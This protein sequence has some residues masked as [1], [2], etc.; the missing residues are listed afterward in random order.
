MK[1]TKK[2]FLNY[3]IV[4]IIIVIAILVIGAN[5]DKLSAFG[6]DRIEF[7]YTHQHDSNP[8]VIGD[9]QFSPSELTYSCGPTGDTIVRYPE[10][11][12]ECWGSDVSYDAG[13]YPFTAGQTILLNQYLS[14][15]LKPQGKVYYNDELHGEYKDESHWKSVYDFTLDPDI[16]ASEIE[17][18]RYYVKLNSNT[19]VLV[20]IHSRLAG[21][22]KEHAGIWSRTKHGL[23]ER[24]ESWQTNMMQI[25]Q[26]SNKYLIELD[27]SEL[28]KATLE[29]Q[30]FV[31][32]DADRKITI[33]QKKPIKLNYEVVMQEPDPSPQIPDGRI[34]DRS[35]T[36]KF[37]AF[38]ADLF[39]KIKGWF[40]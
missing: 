15:T 39:E 16:L 8:L 5:T 33:R 13:S 12:P 7:T 11:Q 22:D 21:F 26:G 23:L 19:D 25:N 38:F 24:G 29:I 27:T 2:G 6:D 4:L 17:S 10:P 35:N 1:Q 28:G 40:T 3:L 18:S 20:M 36:E 9:K 34:D 31:V 30:P 32:I 37:F 14:A